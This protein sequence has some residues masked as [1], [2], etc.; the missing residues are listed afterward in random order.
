MSNNNKKIMKLINFKSLFQRPQKEPQ[1]KSPEQC[2]VCWGYQ[3]YDSQF[4]TLYPDRQI[5]VNNHSYKYM[6][7]QGMLTHYIDGMRLK[8]GEIQACPTCSS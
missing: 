3:Q 2:A 8:K 6:R 7:I 4:K 1:A 5:D